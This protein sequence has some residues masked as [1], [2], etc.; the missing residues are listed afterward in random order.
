MT[1]GHAQE[2]KTQAM[3]M[4]VGKRLRIILSDN[5]AGIDDA[6]LGGVISSKY[7]RLRPARPMDLLWLER[8]DRRGRRRLWPDRRHAGRRWKTWDAGR[9]APDDRHRQDHQGLL[10]RRRRMASWA[11]VKQIVSYQE[12]SLWPEDELR[13]FRRPGRDLRE[14]LRH[15]LRR[16]PQ[17]R[18]QRHQ[19]TA[20]PVQDQYRQGDVGAGPERAGRL[21][22]RPAGGHRRQRQGR[23]QAQHRQQHRSLPGRAP[24]A[25]PICRWSPQK[26]TVKNRISGASK[27][28]SITLFQQ[29]G[30][31]AGAR[32]AP[33]PK[34]SSG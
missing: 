9:P 16:H 15:Q 28:V 7:A 25:S 29:A 33:S 20:D 12:P 32:A 22:G 17:W 31:S 1:E 11:D 34:S 18:G 8:A 6:L 2:L 14:A 30:R 3:A 24:A 26:L 10:A 23:S 21:G 27:E 13:I 5:N 4:Q 19:G